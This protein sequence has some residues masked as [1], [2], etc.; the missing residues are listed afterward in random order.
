MHT[1][2]VHVGV[3]AADEHSAER[4]SARSVAERVA[5]SVESVS[6]SAVADGEVDLD[7]FDALWW[8]RDAPFDDCD[9]PVADAGPAIRAYLDA[10]GGLVLS[11]RALPAVVPLGIDSV[12][13]D[14]T[15]AT[16]SDDVAGYRVREI[17]R[18]HPLFEGFGD[19][20][21]GG[22][23]RIPVV[24][25][26]GEAA[27][28]RYDDL[29]PANGDVLACATHGGHDIH[30]EKAVI[31]WRVGG[32]ADGGDGDRPG[33][34]DGAVL[35]LGGTL[36]FD[37][38]NDGHGY[39]RERLLRNAFATLGRGTLPEFT[40]R[41][42]TPAGFAAVRDRLAD[43]HHRPAYHLSPPANW[44]NDPNGLIE[45]EGEYHVFYQYNPGG[46]FHNAIH[47]GHAVSDDLVHWEDRPVALAPDPDGPDRD[48][49]WSG[50][51]VIDTDG[52]PTLLYTGGR[53][54]DQLPCLATTDDPRLDSWEKHPGNPVIE[55]APEGLNVYETADWAAE[56]RDHNVWREHGVWYHLIG[57]GI[58]GDAEPADRRAAHD[59]GEGETAVDR[60]NDADAGELEAPVG[61]GGD[62]AH[63]GDGAALLYRGDTLDEWEFVGVLHA[64][65][66][67]RG[68]PVWECPELLTFEDARLLHVSDDDRVAYYLG[69]ADLGDPEAPA[70]SDAAVP[71]F[72]VR[73]AGL[74][75]HG[76]FYAPQ[77]LWDEEH[78]RYLTWGWLPETRDGSAQWDA[79]WSGAMSL[80]RVIDTDCDGRLRQRPAP[81]LTAAREDHAL[82]ATLALDA[83]ERVLGVRGAALELGCT[84]RLGD[85]EAV[86]LSVLESPAAG[87]RTVIRYD[88]ETVTVDRGDSGG[89]E[90]I[91]R[92]PRGMPVDGGDDAE[93]SVSLRVFVDGST[94]ELFANERRC[95]TTRVYPTRADAD[96]VSAFAVGGDAEVEMDA[97]TMAGTWPTSTGR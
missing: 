63:E 28:A 56:F 71:A 4:R 90:R 40:G 64:G 61:D 93:R 19:P 36:R 9:A 34:A 54:R 87:E 72:D 14:A 18:D 44:L 91:N 84:L 79:G 10:G 88:G 74:L 20:D 60:S 67:P 31:E 65:E 92:A 97:W 27:Y 48:G 1:A 15:G 89:D 22:P 52:T 11:A 78:D 41:P 43:D 17:H 85:A 68:A 39:E 45:Y 46:P 66:G 83:E 29:L 38:P 95:L 23:P 37:G 2:P 81:E 7:A 69:E 94:L 32:D 73:E 86:G 42:S 53:G 55:S 35:G 82:S 75:D 25:P 70:G 12:A 76:D 8:H 96:R 21:A 13:P 26:G 6:L 33:A 5:A 30:P 24:G 47:W 3:L 80:P 58:A 57:T 62:D 51:T 50:C 16:H 77:S 49:C 59:G